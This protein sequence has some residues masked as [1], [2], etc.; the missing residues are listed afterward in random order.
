[1]GKG[2]ISSSPVHGGGQPSVDRRLP[3]REPPFHLVQARARVRGKV[4]QLLAKWSATCPFLSRSPTPIATGAPT[5]SFPLQSK[6]H[7]HG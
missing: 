1:M 3:A 5:D 7:R 4:K 2:G 6:I